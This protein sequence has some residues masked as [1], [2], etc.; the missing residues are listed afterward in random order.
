M[1]VLDLSPAV[2]TSYYA[3]KQTL[4]YF[5]DTSPHPTVHS[6]PLKFP[7]T[8]SEII[9]NFREH[10]ESLPD[11]FDQ[12]VVVVIDSMASNPGVILP[13]E[14]MVAICKEYK[15]WSVVD[16]AHGVGELLDDALSLGDLPG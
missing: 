1:N 5:G 14:E 7:T 15:A 16:A 2:S 10:L 4:Q 9:K 6:I 11:T 12:K 8:H 3:I 13:W